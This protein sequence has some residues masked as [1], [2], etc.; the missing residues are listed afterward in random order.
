MQSGSKLIL[1]GLFT[2]CAWVA[3]VQAQ[4]APANAEDIVVTA[5]RRDDRLQ[6]VP[7]AITAFNG[8]ALAR[9]GITN[10][11]TLVRN[12][13]GLTF[14]PV[15]PG[16]SNLGLRGL[17]TALGLA[18]TVAVYVNDT[19]FDF[20][21][22]SHAGSPNVDL[23]DLDRVEV[24]RGPQGTLF[25]SSSLG[26]TIRFLLKQPAI[27]K[28]EYAAEGGVNTSSGDLGYTAKGM[29]NV[30]VSPIAA[31]RLVGTY[32]HIAGYID[33]YQAT[34]AGISSNPSPAARIRHNSNDADI[35]SLRATARI[36]PSAEFS[37]TPSVFF[38]R[39]KANDP[40]FTQTNLPGFGVASAIG[41][42]SSQTDVFIANLAIEK[43]LGFASLVSSSSYL[44][45]KSAPRLDYSYLPR[46]FFGL[47][48]PL[49]N[50]EPSSASTFTQEFRL[51]SPS[52]QRFRWVV[53]FYY[54]HTD[55]KLTQQFVSPGL[56]AF[57]A[58]A[59]GGS[60]TPSP[61]YNYGQKT[62][63][64][65]IAGF[66]QVNF[67]VTDTL[68]LVAGARV[69]NLKNSVD[70]SCTD[71]TADSILCGPVSPKVSASKTDVSPRFTLN[72]K[73]SENVTLYATASRGF[74]PG[75]ANTAIPAGLGCVL[76]SAIRPIFNPDSVWNYEVGAKLQSSDRKVT[77]NGAAFQIDQKGVQIAIP[78]PVCGVI[79]FAN[80][81]DA[82]IK[83]AELEA[84]VRPTD[85]FS[86][87]GFMSFIDSK[88][89][90]VPA[91]LGTAGGYKVGD[92]TPETP[93][94]K[95]GASV[96]LTQPL[97]ETWKGYLRS[98][99]QHVGRTPYSSGA[100]VFSGLYRPSY[101]LVG[102][103]IGANSDQ[104]DVG[105]FLRNA[106][107]KRGLLD[108]DTGAVSS[109]PGVFQNVTYTTPRTF[110]ITVRIRG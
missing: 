110:G 27:D 23:F 4:T 79:S 101:D 14:S 17:T 99:W 48:T 12:T 89:T 59:F 51:S 84:T 107:D 28:T 103:Q 31:V 35:W 95:F 90:S 70:P 68:E 50:E 29:V 98:D 43:D 20:R 40:L 13:P 94:W 25:G 81:G 64:Q 18:S 22:D 8:A 49:A 46:A 61:A 109:V 58:D 2:S 47:Y 93:R 74:R 5:Q 102:F 9:L 30:P 67:D 66:A 3:P 57:L 88:F 6:D 56:T 33:R 71:A 26:G 62:T 41:A 44:K 10:T 34:E 21:T 87:N 63:D 53:G 15:G 91:A 77:L 104:Y 16:E 7:Q 96:E 92:P 75:G 82:R 97:N 38:Q 80:A 72:F 78:D 108:V 42:Q 54:S 73:P 105:L 85:F 100:G 1:A 39:T 19:P 55:Q 24:L 86:I 76:G 65:Q 32:D 11:E 52:E 45:K 37:I 69:Y 106:F 83:G 36:E 60:T